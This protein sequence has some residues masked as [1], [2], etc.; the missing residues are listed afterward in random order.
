MKRVYLIRAVFIVVLSVIIGWMSIHSITIP[1]PDVSKD[2]Y[3]DIIARKIEDAT[4]KDDFDNFR[5]LKWKA[6][7]GHEFIWDKNQKQVIVIHKEDK[8]LLNLEF[9]KSSVVLFENAR[10]N[11]PKTRQKAIEKAYKQ[12][13]NDSFWV[14]APFK[15]FD[16]GV[17]RRIVQDGAK[18]LLLVS[19]TQGG[20]TPGDTYVWRTDDN[21]LPTSIQMWTEK[22]PLEGIQ[23]SWEN[24]KTI[25]GKAK[26]AL[27]HKFGPINIKVSNLEAGNTMQDLK[28]NEDPFS[29]F[30]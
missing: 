6:V 10:I 24:Y 27:T 18:K 21:F 30:D 15:L 5:Y 7:R 12:F 8:V 13:C 29:D 3:A 9:L 16:E 19:Y 28:L 4:G 26:I 2:V 1:K 14:I 25:S 17:E 22:I 23:V 20:T 11:D